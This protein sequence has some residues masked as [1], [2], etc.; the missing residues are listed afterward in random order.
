MYYVPVSTTFPRAP[1]TYAP[2]YPTIVERQPIEIIDSR[3]NGDVSRMKRELADIREE[4]SEL[5]LERPTTNFIHIEPDYP[6]YYRCVSPVPLT[7]TR[8]LS[9]AH[10]CSIC[11][12]YVIDSPYPPPSSPRWYRTTARLQNDKLSEYLS[13]QLDLAKLRQRYIPE[14]RPVWIPTAYKNDYS[15]RRWATRDSRFSEP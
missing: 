7:C 6:T 9:P 10:Y 14:T 12:D 11:D 2:I 15:H 1:V 13:R 3:V 8:P 4:I 5:R